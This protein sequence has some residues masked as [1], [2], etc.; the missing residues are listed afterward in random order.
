M[1]KTEK[2]K[3]ETLNDASGVLW[4]SVNSVP[5]PQRAGGQASGNVLNIDDIGDPGDIIARVC[6]RPTLDDFFPFWNFIRTEQIPVIVNIN[7]EGSSGDYFPDKSRVITSGSITV[8]KKSSGHSRSENVPEEFERFKLKVKAIGQP[9]ARVKLYKVT[10]WPDAAGY[11]SVKRMIKFGRKLIS[12]RSPPLIHCQA[13]LGRSG[14]VVLVMNLLLLEGVGMLEK[15]TA[16]VKLAELIS[17]ARADRNDSRFVTTPDQFLFLLRVL[18]KLTGLS[19][20]EIVEQVNSYCGLA[21]S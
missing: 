19:S 17:Q 9:S 11:S 12:L 6:S 10:D 1:K 14:T 5:L 13:G 3:A 2:E 4:E 8:T 21:D 16:V 18:K 7:E 15:E 20:R